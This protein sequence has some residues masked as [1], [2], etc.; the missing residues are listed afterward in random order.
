MKCISTNI[1]NC[2]IIQRGLE[3]EKVYV[4]CNLSEKFL[5]IPL[6][7]ELDLLPQDSN[8]LVIDNITGTNLNLDKFELNPYQVVWVSLV[9]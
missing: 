3:D 4:I 5:N 7:N 8:K 1:A 2:V 9:D 6:S